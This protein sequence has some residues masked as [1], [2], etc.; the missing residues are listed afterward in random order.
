MSQDSQP[1]FPPEDDYD[2]TEIQRTSENP[3]KSHRLPSDELITPEVRL[4]MEIMQSLTEPCDRK[5]YGIRKREAAK[6][7][8]VTLRSIERLLKK[9]QEQGLVGL[10]TTRSDKGKL[11]ISEDWQEFIFETYK[12]GNKGS[13]RM[14][15]NQV[16]LRV[17]GRAKQLGLK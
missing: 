3:A 1:F 14:L 11:R 2:P 9:H 10:T 7:L 16:F 13:K 4:R 17:K 12:E 5:T 15:R 8:G 6:K